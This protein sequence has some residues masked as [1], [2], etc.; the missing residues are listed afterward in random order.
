MSKLIVFYCGFSI[1]SDLRIYNSQED[2]RKLSEFH[3]IFKIENR[4]YPC[5]SDM[6]LYKYRL[7]W[8][9]VYSPFKH[10]FHWHCIDNL[11][12]LINLIIPR[13]IDWLIM[14]NYV[15]ISPVGMYSTRGSAG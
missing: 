15:L 10:L 11:I 9:Y 14:F 1:K 7:T 13:L 4:L 5:E 12:G 8:N 6:P 3:T 2:E